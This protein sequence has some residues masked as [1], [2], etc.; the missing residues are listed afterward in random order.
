[1]G[2]FMPRFLPGG[3]R[4][5]SRSNERDTRQTCLRRAWRFLMW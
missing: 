4:D 2:T 3:L 1:V 5:Q